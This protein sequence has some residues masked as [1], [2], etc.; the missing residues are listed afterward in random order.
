MGNVP[1]P[2]GIQAGTEWRPPGPG[3]SPEHL[4]D[5]FRLRTCVGGEPAGPGDV[6]VRL[7]RLLRPRRR[8]CGQEHFQGGARPSR[9]FGGSVLR[10]GG[11]TVQAVR[12][13]PVSKRGV[14]RSESP[15]FPRSRQAKREEGEDVKRHGYDA[16][17]IPNARMEEYNRKMIGRFFHRIPMQSSPIE[18]EVYRF[19]TVQRK[20]GDSVLQNFQPL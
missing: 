2:A 7:L 10:T 5:L 15:S 18:R 19:R 8:Q 13:I 20:I 16:S 6:P 9:L 14:G 12:S 11:L 3:R 17:S 4:P 1:V